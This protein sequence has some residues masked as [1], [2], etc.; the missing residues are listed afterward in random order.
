M[1]DITLFSLAMDTNV[2]FAN[3]PSCR[4]IDIRAKYILG[5]HRLLSWLSHLEF[6]FEPLFL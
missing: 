2:S 6:A 1:A 3:L 5:V 4:A